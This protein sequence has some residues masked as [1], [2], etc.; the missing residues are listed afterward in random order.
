VAPSWTTAS[1]HYGDGRSPY[2]RDS[3]NRLR[4]RLDLGHVLILEQILTKDKEK[5]TG[6]YS[7]LIFVQDS[8]IFHIEANLRPYYSI[9][10]WEFARIPNGHDQKRQGFYFF[11]G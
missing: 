8:I 5:Q 2:T 6:T 11:S 9:K 7:Y 4:Q 3:T 1:G 10:D